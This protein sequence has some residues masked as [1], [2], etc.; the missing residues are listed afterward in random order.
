M[1]KKTLRF[2]LLDVLY[3]AMIVIPL[4]AVMALNVMTKPASDGIEIAGARIFFTIQMPI[5]EL[6]I[7]ESQV[8]TWAILLSAFGL[9]LFMAHGITA[10]S[11]SRRHLIAEWIVE[12][13]DSMV[14]GNMGE[15]FAGFSPF[16]AAILMLSALSSLLTLIGLYPPTSDLNVVAGWAILVMILITHYKMKGGFL[17][18]VKSFG[19]PMPALA[20]LNIISEVATPLSMSFR[21]YGNVL[22]GTVISAL[23][24]AGLQSLSHAI[25]GWLPG[26]LGQFPLFQI[27]LPAVLSVY[28]DIFSGCMQAFIFAMLTMLYIAGG[29]PEDAWRARQE[30]KRQKKLAKSHN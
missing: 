11:K 10:D 12:K 23:I 8:N 22:S 21:H 15:Y 1:N 2:R 5:Q 28:F 4:I 19:E 26:A 30:K 29:F 18:Y 27:G 7:T 25:L 20:P 3:L 24:A 14:H 13:T 17:G 6:P 9:C 16:I